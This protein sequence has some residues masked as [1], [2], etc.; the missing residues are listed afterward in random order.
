MKRNL[1]KPTSATYD[2]RQ[3]WLVETIN[4]KK[5]KRVLLQLP[6]GL[7]QYGLELAQLIENNTEAQ[8][9]ISADPCYGACDLALDEAKL[10]GA[11]LVAHYGHSML[12]SKTET[13]AVYIEAKSNLKIHDAVKRALPLMKNFNRVGLAT[14]AQHTHRL[15][16]ARRILLKN[17]KDVLV[18]AAS[19]RV[20]HNG[21]ILGCDFS[22]AKTI[23]D[24]VDCFLF[25]GGGDFH[26]VGLALSTGKP[27]VAADPYLN[28][29]RRI[30]GLL[31]RILRKRWVAIC[32]AKEATR[33][34]I[35]VGLKPGQLD[36]E[37]ALEIRGEIKRQGKEPVILCSR[38]ITPQ[39][40]SSFYQ[41]HALIDT[42]CPRIAIDDAP[43]FRQ[44]VLTTD[45]A[46]VM[47][48]RKSWED[49]IG[50]GLCA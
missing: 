1:A 8:V 14:T 7:K 16:D 6:E 3:R 23:S 19:G 15:T 35:L 22:T 28:K 26:P 38:E 33:I 50:K 39:N 46:E 45:E 20:K 49:H 13:P 36:L 10:L 4:E 21:Q 37:K 43:R 24:R 34:G 44:V 31:R 42:A 25:I 2:L 30:S 17:G 29:T 18:G 47:L 5:A 32:R 48:G 9:I 11:D 41:L 40:L 12:R 27:V